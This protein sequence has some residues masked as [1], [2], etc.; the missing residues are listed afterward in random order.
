M[1]KSKQKRIKKHKAS[2]SGS[3]SSGSRSSSRSSRASSS[4]SSSSSG[5][6]YGVS[7]RGSGGGLMQSM[8]SG[9]KRAAGV[10]D[11]TGGESDKPSTLS[12]VLWTV[13]LLAAVGALLYRW[14]G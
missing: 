11:D 12:N 5:G 1:A 3:S 7:K 8:R 13:L 14:Y 6:G 9:F 10:G 4:S 2:K